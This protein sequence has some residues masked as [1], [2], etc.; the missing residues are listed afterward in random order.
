M[1]TTCFLQAISCHYAS[2]TDCYY[3]DTEGTTHENLAEEVMGIAKKRLGEDV[4]LQFSVNIGWWRG[5]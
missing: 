1:K 2:T 3:I 4:Q 5:S